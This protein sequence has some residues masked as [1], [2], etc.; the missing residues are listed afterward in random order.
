M[1]D[2]LAVRNWDEFQQYKDRDPKWIKLHRDIL[3]N[4]EF[5]HLTE[6][7]QLHLVKIWLLASKLENKIPNDAVWIAR[8]IGAKSK[9]DTKQLITSGF[10]VLYKSVQNCTEMYLE[11]ETET[12]TETER[13]GARTRASRL[14]KDWQPTEADVKYCRTKRPDLHP[15]AVAEN[16][17]DYWISKPGTAGT[18]LDWS[19]TWRGWVRNEKQQ[20]ANVAPLADIISPTHDRIDFNKLRAAEKA[21]D[22]VDPYAEQRKRTA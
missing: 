8:Q 11:T 6:V 21:L 3:T 20:R 18:K 10:L 19:A 14:Q 1:T 2:Y 7:Q 13:E 5:E 17:R 9:V 15:P 12:E 16:F 22:P 4:Y